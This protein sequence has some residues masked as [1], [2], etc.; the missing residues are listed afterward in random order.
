MPYCPF[1]GVPL[2]ERADGNVG[3]GPMV[4]TF[5][6]CYDCPDPTCGCHWFWDQHDSFIC[7]PEPCPL[8]HRH[9]KKE[10]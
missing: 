8:E 3:E 9:R 6:I 10:D 4:D 2:V 7:N 1:D 5:V